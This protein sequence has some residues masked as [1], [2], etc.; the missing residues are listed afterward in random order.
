MIYLL[1]DPPFVNL[2]A[3][4]GNLLQYLTIG[5]KENNLRANA[6]VVAKHFLPSWA[7]LAAKKWS[8]SVAPG[9]SSLTTT[10]ML[11]PV[12]AKKTTPVI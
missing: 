2:F 4:I 5:F 11:A 12:H 3:N 7:F 6:N 1:A 9:A 8:E 10:R